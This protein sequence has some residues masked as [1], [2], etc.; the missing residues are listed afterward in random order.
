M[1]NGVYDAIHIA[2]HD[3]TT[4]GHMSTADRYAV[5]PEQVPINGGMSVP[6]LGTGPAAKRM[7]A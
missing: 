6:D 7:K 4:I 5:V 3:T 1:E 2:P